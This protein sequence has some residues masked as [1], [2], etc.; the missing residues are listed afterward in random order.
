VVPVSS[1]GRL[2]DTVGGSGLTSV[3]SVGVTSVA[4]TNGGWVPFSQGIHNSLLDPG[5]SA[6][7]T[8]EL[9]SQIADFFAT[10]GDFITITNGT[11]IAP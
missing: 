5:P 1:T 4:G 7:T 9:Q 10:G 6:A 2:I 11:V 8:L 3:N